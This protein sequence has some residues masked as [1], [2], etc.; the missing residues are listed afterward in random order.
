MIHQAYILQ[1]AAQARVQFFE[2]LIR[3]DDR[4]QLRVVTVVEQ[5]KELLLRPGRAGVGAKVIE[6]QQ[7]RG[8]QLVEQGCRRLPR[9][10]GRR[11]RA[12]DRASQA[13]P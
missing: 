6:N 13:Q 10:W 2:T 9:C 7:R 12:G 1:T 3:G 11:P 4:R 5:L 8:T